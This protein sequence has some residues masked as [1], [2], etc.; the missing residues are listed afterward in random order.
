MLDAGP[1]GRGKADEESG[2]RRGS[3]KLRWED[4][5][6]EDLAGVR[7]ELRMRTRVGGRRYRCPPHPGLKG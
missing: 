6:K 7:G 3:P 5:V 2:R 4:C 1:N